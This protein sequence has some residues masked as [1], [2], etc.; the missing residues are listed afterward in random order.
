MMDCEQESMEHQK[1]PQV[2]HT[3][4]ALLE[5]GASKQWLKLKDPTFTGTVID[6]EK[7][8]SATGKDVSILCPDKSPT[9]SKEVFVWQ[10][11]SDRWK[12]EHIKGRSV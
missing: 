7:V 3:V 12:Q 4:T 10:V 6:V 5:F 9:G 8:L 1:D 2:L 11:W